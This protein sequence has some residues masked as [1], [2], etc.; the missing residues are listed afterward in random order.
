MSEINTLYYNC[1]LYVF[2]LFCI[3]L[4]T[5]NCHR[6]CIHKVLHTLKVNSRGERVQRQ[7]GDQAVVVAVKIAAVCCSCSKKDVHVC[8]IY[9]MYI[10]THMPIVTGV[11]SHL[12]Y[13]RNSR[14]RYVLT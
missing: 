14:E 13:T 7:V 10:A 9:C 5:Y 4:C 8:T 6:F 12:S 2:N 11:S 3:R 1:T